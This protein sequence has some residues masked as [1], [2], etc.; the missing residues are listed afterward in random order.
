MLHC[1]VLQ[2]RPLVVPHA[3]KLVKLFLLRALPTTVG[4][5]KPWRSRVALPKDAGQ[6]S[7]RWKVRYKFVDRKEI[8]DNLLKEWHPFV[9]N[10]RTF[11]G[12]PGTDHAVLSMASVL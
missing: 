11:L 4:S 9:G 12:N 2:I 7:V 8:P 3:A 5:L 6:V 1:R 10:Y